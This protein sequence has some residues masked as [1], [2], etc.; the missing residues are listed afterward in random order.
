VTDGQEPE[1]GLRERKKR[2]CRASLVDAAQELVARDGLD[3][4]TVEEICTEAGV[5]PRTFFNY[6]ESKDD[7][8]LGHT[9]WAVDPAAAEVFAS[10][11]PTGNHVADLG[12]LLD[13]VLGEVAVDRDRVARA[14]G[15]V[16]SEPRLLA[17][18]MM[19]IEQ[20]HSQL[21][22]LAAARLGEPVDSP[23]A[24][25]LAVLAGGMARASF[26]RWHT[27]GDADLH[28]AIAATA[29]DLQSLLTSEGQP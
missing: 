26:T 24:V 18:Q 28:A 11:G 5:S 17:R 29:A 25:L 22:A 21:T 4:V 12:V 16:A 13:A 15:L 20:K 7:A 27:D 14:M 3:Q 23:R 19:T 9:P 8:V 1:L 6:F 2:A 10:G